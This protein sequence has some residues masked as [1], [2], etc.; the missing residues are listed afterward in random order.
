MS[1]RYV[2]V[3][4]DNTRPQRNIR[5]ALS[6]SPLGPWKNISGP[7]T[8]KFTEGPSAVKIGEDWIIYFESYHA[9]HYSAAKTRDFKTFTDITKEIT[10]PEGHKHGTALQIPREVLDGLLR[11]PAL[12]DDHNPATQ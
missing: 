11:A 1:D 7:F 2:L 12:Q 9:R 3:L 4:K 10:F 5:V 6:E 8:E